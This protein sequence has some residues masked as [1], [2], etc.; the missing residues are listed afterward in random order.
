[1][2]PQILP[3]DFG[4]EPVNSGDMAIVNCAATKGDVPIKI[5]WS[6]NGNEI[7]GVNG[8][9]A[10]DTNKRVNQL[11]IENVQGYHAGTYTCTAEN[12]VGAVSV[13]ARLN[14]NGIILL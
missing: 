12:P 8:I 13:S 11:S 1:M 5:S 3:F 9:S 6:L 10:I 14:V 7:D 4:E 2:P